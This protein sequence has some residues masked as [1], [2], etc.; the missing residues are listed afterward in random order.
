MISAL[1]SDIKEVLI[2]LF[3]LRENGEIQ[4]IFLSSNVC[5]LTKDELSFWLETN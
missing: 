4:F 3:S 2:I 5:S 1:L